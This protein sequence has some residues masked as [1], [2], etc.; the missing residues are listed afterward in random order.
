MSFPESAF[1]TFAFSHPDYS[2]TDWEAEFNRMVQRNQAID[3][4]LHGEI[5]PDYVEDLLAEHGLC[6][7]EWAETAEDNLLY[8]AG[9]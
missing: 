4:L 1:L 2:D 9:F 5:E 6:P 7:F 3:R 8:L